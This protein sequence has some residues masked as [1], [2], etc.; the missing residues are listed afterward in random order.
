MIARACEIAGKALPAGTAKEFEDADFV[1]EY[2][3]ESV[4]LLSGAGIVQGSNNRFLPRGYCTRAEAAV[5]LKNV[6]D[7]IEG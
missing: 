3:K 2:A 7:K 6:L 5:M 4:D 1:S